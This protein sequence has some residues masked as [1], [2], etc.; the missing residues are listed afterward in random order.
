[1]SEASTQV[2]RRRTRRTVVAIV[3]A[4][5]IVA[6]L[7]VIAWT[8]WGGRGG[9][10]PLAQRALYVDPDSLAAR[11]ALDGETAAERDAATVLAARATAIWLTPERD[12]AGRAGET[13]AAV[14]AAATTRNA[15]PVF[16]VY[17]I[18]DRDC[19]N[20]S[21]G[22]LPPREYLAWV[23]EIAAALGQRAAVV[24]LE[25]DALALAPECPDPDG[26]VALVADALARFDGTGAILYLDGGH[27]AWLPA[28]RM[29]TLLADAGVAGARGFATNVSN[30]QTTEAERT[31]AAAVATALRDAHGIDGAHAVVDVSRNGNGP[32]GDGAWCNVPGRAIGEDPHAIE[33]DDVLDG[34]LWVKPPGE[35]DGECNGGP[36]AGEWW[37]RQAVELV[38]NA[39]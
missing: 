35:S 34:V 13:V 36:P 12:P 17:G 39:G 32:P 38:R 33:G 25:P 14:V 37:P 1:M 30:T 18:T 27:S 20:H 7:A 3:A 10:G 16:A 8:L 31:Y 28:D 6:G 29:A 5:V 11:A 26:R 21:A 22:G 4:V 23:D 15:L 9:G 2:G 19:G 24:V